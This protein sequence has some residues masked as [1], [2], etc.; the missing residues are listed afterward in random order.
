MSATGRIVRL[1]LFL[2]FAAV[3]VQAQ[4]SSGGGGGADAFLQGVAE[5]FRVSVEETFVLS[6]WHLAKDEIPVVLYLAGRGGVS[7]DVVVAQRSGGKSWFDIASGFGVTAGDFH[8]EVGPDPGT[9]AGVMAEFESRPMSQWSHIRIGDQDL[10]A[11]VNVRFLSRFLERPP[12]E[13]VAAWKR[14]RSFAEA[15]GELKASSLD[16]S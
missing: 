12:F 16:R 2:A 3:P 6:Q 10:V 9:L 11:L 14:Q 8:M 15:Y 7:P 5:Y 4:P 13:I 1:G